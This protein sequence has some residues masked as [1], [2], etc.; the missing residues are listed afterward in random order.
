MTLISF[1]LV[2]YDS[3]KFINVFCLFFTSTFLISDSIDQYSR[4]SELAKL[5]FKYDKDKMISDIHSNDPLV[6][7]ILDELASN[8]EIYKK[9]WRFL[10]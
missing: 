10:S 2:K 5:N 3:F 6:L 1:F 4:D 9:A 8:Y 7:I